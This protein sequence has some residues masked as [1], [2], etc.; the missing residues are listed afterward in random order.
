MT[1]AP[2]PAFHRR[3]SFRSRSTCLLRLL[4]ARDA[5]PLPASTTVACLLG[6]YTDAESTARAARTGHLHLTDPLEPRTLAQ[7][8][9]A[10]LSSR[11]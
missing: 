6:V 2:Y 10:V 9:A 5:E 4:G 11:R 8:S 7:P 1:D 3:S